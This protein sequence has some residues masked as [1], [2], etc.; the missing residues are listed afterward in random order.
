[1]SLACLF[2][3]H[4]RLFISPAHYRSIWG[5]LW[6]QKIQSSGRKRS[7]LGD[8]GKSFAS[9]IL[10]ENQ[11]FVSCD[12]GRVMSEESKA[13]KQRSSDAAGSQISAV[14]ENNNGLFRERQNLLTT[15]MTILH[16]NIVKPVLCNEK[17]LVDWSKQTTLS[18]LFS[19]WHQSC[20]L[21]P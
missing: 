11:S 8:L 7:L 5:F 17:Q 10:S 2:Q 9:E 18:F 15:S 13:A 12:Y 6:L 21:E 1:M 4:G 20:S 16:G 14:Q 3:K 19:F